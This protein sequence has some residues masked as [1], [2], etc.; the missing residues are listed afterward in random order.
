MN[1]FHALY[2]DPVTKFTPGYVMITWC[3]IVTGM[4]TAQDGTDQVLWYLE[5]GATDGD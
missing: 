2:A 4:L 1:E 5:W 3:D